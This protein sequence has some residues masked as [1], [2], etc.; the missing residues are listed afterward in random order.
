VNLLKMGKFSFNMARKSIGRRKL[1]AALTI[2]G[3]VIGVATIVS[4][5][6][7]GEGMQ[8]EIEFNLEKMLGAGV[9]ISAGESVSI[10]EY[11]SEYVLQVPGVKDCVPTISIMSND[12][13]SRIG[14]GEHGSFVSIVMGIELNCAIDLYQLTLSEGM[15]P[16]LGETNFVI[17]SASTADKSDLHLNDTITLSATSG[18]IGEPFTVA[19]IVGS[20]SSSGFG[21]EI[22]YYIS[23]QDAQRL[24]DKEGYVSS[25]LV[26]LD[27]PDQA[28]SVK[29]ILTELFPEATI[30]TP[31]AIL[32]RIGDVLGTVNGALMALGSVSLVVGAIGVMNTIT[33]SIYERTRE[34]GM[35]KAVGGKRRHILFIFLSESAVIGV[36]GGIIGIMFGISM[37]YG[38]S[39]LVTMLGS[40]VT[41][42]IIVSPQTV[43][44]GFTIG[45]VLAVAAGFYPSW[46][47]SNMRPVEALR[48]E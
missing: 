23:L 2:M 16:D 4:L 45:L 41:L 43:L 13:R 20:S 8:T 40:T 29:D 14:S 32:S 36:I 15:I 37:A 42:P 12:F 21:I 9:T 22:G 24:Y 48:Y 31:E 18:G 44:T 34:I 17:I 1:R 47:A 7:V 5:I 28:D 26:I 38:L 46:K 11:I 27:D 10:P 39:Y 19:G 25:L 35:M 6:S 30:T 33:M 3:I